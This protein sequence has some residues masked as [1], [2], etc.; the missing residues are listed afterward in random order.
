MIILF[1]NYRKITKQFQM[2][3]QLAEQITEIIK[4]SIGV[5]FT[6]SQNNAGKGTIF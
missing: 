1:F 6:N 2:S 4:N 3:H 5:S